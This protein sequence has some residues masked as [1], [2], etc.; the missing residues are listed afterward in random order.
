MGPTL[1]IDLRTAEE[2]SAAPNWAKGWRTLDFQRTAGADI[3]D[4]IGQSHVAGAAH[5]TLWRVDLMN[6]DRIFDYMKQQWWDAKT[7]AQAA[8]W[9]VLSGA[10][11]Q[12]LRIREL[13]RRGLEGLYE[14]TLETGGPELC[15]VL[16]LLASMAD[17]VLIHC[18]KGKDRTGL[19]AALVLSV[20]GL[21][22]AAI[23][24]DYAAS[25]A[26]FA[27]EWSPNPV[28]SSPISPDRLDTVQFSRAPASAMAHTLQYLRSRWGSP[29]QY[30]D[31]IGF[32]DAWRDR[33]RR[34][35]A[36]PS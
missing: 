16:T 32:G 27:D 9:E 18:V 30:L 12:R 14:A 15:F 33:L 29:D 3:Q 4:L 25:D 20:L 26:A 2:R 22:D 8:M 7:R 23:V 35:F 24:A 36:P 1:V 17:P 11:L 34:S 28:P 21:D 10:E 6:P 5:R 31:S 19:V 13:N